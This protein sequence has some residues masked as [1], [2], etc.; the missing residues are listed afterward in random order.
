ML[1]K[2][3]PLVSILTFIL[4]HQ[5]VLFFQIALSFVPCRFLI[6]LFIFPLPIS[7]ANW[8]Y[9]SLSF[10]VF[11]SPPKIKENNKAFFFIR[12]LL[13]D[14]L[15]KNLFYFFSI[16]QALLNQTKQ[17]FKLSKLQFKLN[18]QNQKNLQCY[19][20]YIW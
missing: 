4:L 9:P 18:D 3:A 14:S 13:F 1:I 7:F 15:D 16:A 2:I 11:N 17:K 19:S 12:H 6:L 5:P 20:R 10:T 8:L